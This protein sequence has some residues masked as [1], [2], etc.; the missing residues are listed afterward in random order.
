MLIYALYIWFMLMM[1][2]F[3]DWYQ[4]VHQVP[5]RVRRETFG[6]VP[7]YEWLALPED[8]SEEETESER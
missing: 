6:M 3:F 5:P 2:V 7:M 1:K 4:S 8:V